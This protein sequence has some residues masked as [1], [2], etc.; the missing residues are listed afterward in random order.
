MAGPS[1]AW[2]SPRSGRTPPSRRMRVGLASEAGQRSA[3]SWRRANR[4]VFTACLG[5][6]YLCPGDQLRHRANHLAESGDI[7]TCCRRRGVPTGKSGRW[8]C[9]RRETAAEFKISPQ[10]CFDAAQRVRASSKGSLHFVENDRYREA[11]RPHGPGGE[12]LAESPE[13]LESLGGVS[14]EK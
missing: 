10:L 12:R 4:D 9:H 7:R 6:P 13:P 2:L 3:A 11:G 14:G 8:A 1:A 5:C